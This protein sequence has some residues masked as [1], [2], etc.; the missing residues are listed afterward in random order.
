MM[1]IIRRLV[2]LSIALLAAAA[3]ATPTVTFTVNAT[4]GNMTQAGRLVA[5]TQP[6]LVFA[7][8]SGAW[9]DGGVYKC[10]IKPQDDYETVIAIATGAAFH[11]DGALLSVVIDLNTTEAFNYLGDEPRAPVMIHISDATA[12]YSVDYSVTLWNNVERPADTLPS[13]AGLAYYTADEVDALVAAIN[14]GMDPIGDP[15]DG[16]TVECA[17]DGQL[18]LGNVSAAELLYLINTYAAGTT[19]ASTDYLLLY[20]A[21]DGT[22]RRITL[23]TLLTWIGA[24]LP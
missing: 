17:D 4:S 16:W 20:D 21:S 1:I 5:G 15:I 3:A 12:A 22:H 2:C 10:T 11:V 14:E 24:N 19:L 13:S 18:Q 6:T 23:N 9:F 7:L 8:A